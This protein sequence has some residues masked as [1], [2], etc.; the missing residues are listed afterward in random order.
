MDIK[1]EIAK[2]VDADVQ[3]WREVCGWAVEQA[4][5]DERKRC[6][7]IVQLARF[8]EIDTDFRS[9]VGRIKNGDTIEQIKAEGKP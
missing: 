5:E 4:V 8:G 9:I 7:E 2:L 3:D 1:A 6:E